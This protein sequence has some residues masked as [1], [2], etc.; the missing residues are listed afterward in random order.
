[1][2][3]YEINEQIESLLSRE[4]IDPETGEILDVNGFD[5]LKELEL[6]RD[7]KIENTGRFNE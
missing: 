6:A 5:Q 4:I 3:L 7:V 2:K 1:M